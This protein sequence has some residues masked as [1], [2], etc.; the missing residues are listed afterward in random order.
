MMSPAREQPDCCASPVSR[1]FFITLVMVISRNLD[2]IFFLMKRICWSCLQKSCFQEAPISSPSPH[3]TSHFELLVFNILF[4][5]QQNLSLKTGKKNPSSSSYCSC[6]CFHPQTSKQLQFSYHP[7]SIKPG[8]TKQK[9][10]TQIRGERRGRSHT[11]GVMQKLNPKHESKGNKKTKNTPPCSF[12]YRTCAP[13]NKIK[14]QRVFK[15]YTEEKLTNKKP[16]NQTKQQWWNTNPKQ[17]N[18]THNKTNHSFP[19]LHIG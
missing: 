16:K 10:Q 19:H 11:L 2:L 8:K 15:M 12:L 17:K 3:A 14:L 4:W 1:S 5:V 6:S 7:F 13:Q 9:K 18:T